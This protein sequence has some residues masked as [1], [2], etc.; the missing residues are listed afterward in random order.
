MKLDLQTLERWLWD[1][2]DILR[3]SID[4]SDFKNYIFG[5]LFLKRANDVFEEEVERVMEQKGL[6]QKEVEEEKDY[7]MFFV[8]AIARWTTVTSLTENIGEAI[9]KAF[10]AIEE[11]NP[12]LN[13]EGVMTA[14]H[15]GDKQ[16]LTDNV[17]QRLLMHFNKYSLRNKDLFTP[18]L[19]GTAYEYLIKMFADDAGK[20]GGEFYTPKG[21]VN[22]LIDLIKPEPGNKVYDPTC[23]SGGMLIEAAKFI[24][25]HHGKTGEHVNVSLFGQEK[26][27]GTWAI[28]KINMIFHNLMDADIRKGDT[29]DSPKHLEGN[30]LMT[31][32]RV[33]ANPPFSQVKWWDRAEVIAEEEA[34]AKGDEDQKKKKPAPNYK[35]HVSDSFGRFSYGIPPRSYGDLA[36]LQHMAAVLE[37]KGRM[38]IVLPHGVLFRGGAEAEIRQGILEEDILEAVVGLPSKLFYNTGIPASILIVNKNKPETL[39]NRVIFIDAS[40]NYKE[41]KNQNSLEK[42]HI[43]KVVTAYDKMEEVEKFMRIVGMEEIGENDFNLN[44]ARYIDTSEEEEIVDIAGT[45]EN[46]RTIEA[47]EKEIDD[48]LHGFLKELGF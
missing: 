22:L 33:I 14:V 45:L 39:R 27:L 35:K 8:P 4:S 47:K 21:V 12:D 42:E 44:I 3:G 29:L 28:C 1:S 16:V 15:F 48:R 19:L 6:S 40:S 31:F 7:H 37:K 13:I 17:L 32:D 5:L 11:Q 10:G 24:A 9:D 20:K 38:G 30:E 43:H 18:D 2:A 23:G 46:I 41:G 25:G 26:N 34:K 36:F